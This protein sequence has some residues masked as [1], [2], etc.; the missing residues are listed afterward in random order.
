MKRLL[1]ILLCFFMALACYSQGTFKYCTNINGIWGKWNDSYSMFNSYYISKIQKQEFVIYNEYEHPSNYVM[2]FKVYGEMVDNDKKS[3]K[4]HLK[5]GEWYKLKGEVEIFTDAE[6]FVSSFPRV[7]SH[8]KPEIRS[9]KLP[10]TIG[11]EPY[12][13]H[14]ITLNIWFDSYALGIMGNN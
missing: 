6:T 3:R 9:V 13:K 5:S 8:D 11:I 12:K 14:P 2:R 10:A 1:S 7:A 4:Q